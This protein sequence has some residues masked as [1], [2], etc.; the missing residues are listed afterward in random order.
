MSGARWESKEIYKISQIYQNFQMVHTP[1]VNFM[2]CKLQFNRAVE[3]GE[4][5]KGRGWETGDSNYPV[6]AEGIPK[7][8]EKCGIQSL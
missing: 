7:G 4:E 5:G 6:V 3:E 1:S 2:G 8:R